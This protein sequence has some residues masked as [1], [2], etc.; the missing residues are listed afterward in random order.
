LRTSN[1]DSIGIYTG[2]LKNEMLKTKSFPDIFP[3]EFVNDLGELKKKENLAVETHDYLTYLSLRFYD[4]FQRASQQKTLLLDSLNKVLGKETLAGIRSDH[5][6][7]ALENVVTNKNYDLPYVRIG[8]ELVRTQDNIYQEP[9][10]N[11]GRTRL[12]S[13]K[14]LLN[15]Q[16]TD[17]IWFNISVIWLFTALCYLLVLFN[18]AA[19]V[20]GITSSKRN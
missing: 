12:F 7:Q 18:A 5:F 2:L 10:S 19:L 9:T 6:N 8:S 3:F 17:T 15:S 13:P 20:R 11:Y 4:Q 1:E 14:K 16:K